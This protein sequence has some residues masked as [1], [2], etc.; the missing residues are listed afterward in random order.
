MEKTINIDGRDITFRASAAI[1][2]LYRIKFRRDIFSDMIKISED[3]KASK[4]KAISAEALSAFE[5][6]AYLM[7]RHADPAQVQ[8]KTVEEWLDNFSTFSIYKIFPEIIGLWADNME[9]KS[10]PKKKQGR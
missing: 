9:T 3:I 8:K 4:K 6:I 2:R 5:N 7:A 1:P 10:E